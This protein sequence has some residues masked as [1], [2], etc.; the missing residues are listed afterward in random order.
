MF[1]KIAKALDSIINEKRRLTTDLIP[2]SKA[3]ALDWGDE[4]EVP[5]V[6]KLDPIFI[7]FEVLLF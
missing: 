1:I 3:L 6:L 4:K 5:L 7:P 2:Q